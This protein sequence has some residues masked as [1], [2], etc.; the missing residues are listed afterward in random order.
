MILQPL[1][2]TE[3][4]NLSKNGRAGVGKAFQRYKHFC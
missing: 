4:F 2:T 3:E 1:N